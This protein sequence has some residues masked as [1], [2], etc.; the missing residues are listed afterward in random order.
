VIPAGFAKSPG[1]SENQKS[2]KEG[3]R[4]S[5]F[6]F[7]RVRADEPATP[8][9]APIAAA[10][11]PAQKPAGKEKDTSEDTKRSP[12]FTPMLAT[13]GTV[14]LFT[15]ETADTLPKGGFGSSHVR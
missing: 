11:F 8:E 12:K 15:V 5:V 6:F 13:T 10:A 14:G 3:R 9:A 4:Y 1:K 2:T 7:I